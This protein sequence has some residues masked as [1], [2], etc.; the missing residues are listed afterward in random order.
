MMEDWP[1]AMLANGPAWTMQGWYSAVHIRVG[2]MVLRIQAVMAP[3]TSR[4]PVVTG[5]P[6]LSKATVISSSRL[7]R[8]ARSLM[9]ERM[10]ISSEETAIPNRLCMV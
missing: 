10:A 4:S 5:L 3:P 6:F 7:R 9:M 8:S 1:T 2:L